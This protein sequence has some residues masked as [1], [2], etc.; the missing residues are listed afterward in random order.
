[1]FLSV[2]HCRVLETRAVSMDRDRPIP[3]L[4][5]SRITMYTHFLALDIQ[6]ILIVL[7]KPAQSMMLPKS[8]KNKTAFKQT[9]RQ[10]T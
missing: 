8:L 1:M 5:S 3:L 10:R 2:M 4:S 6:I 9:T 7:A